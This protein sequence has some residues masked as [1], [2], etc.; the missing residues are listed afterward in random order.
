MKKPIQRRK[1]S[2]LYPFLF[3]LILIIVALP[4]DITA[5]RHKLTDKLSQADIVGIWEECYHP[6]LKGVR[7]VHIFE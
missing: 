2:L 6:Q 7:M 1:N 5:R 3:L 4:L